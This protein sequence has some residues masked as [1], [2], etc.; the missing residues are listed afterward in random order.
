MINVNDAKIYCKE[1]ISKIENY[2]KAVAD[3][4]QT[5]HCHHRTEIWW[6]CSV[7]D[8]I[9]NECYYNRKARELIFLTPSDHRRLHNENLTNE[10]RRKKSETMKGKFS[11]KKHPLYGKTGT[12]TG[13][14]HSVET[15]IKMSA[16]HKGMTWKVINGKRTWIL[17]G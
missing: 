9:E 16:V 10:T 11:G 3:T 8:L 13:K 14:H 2:D 17:K 5:W 15:K 1:D 6:N 4:S 7:N 12:F